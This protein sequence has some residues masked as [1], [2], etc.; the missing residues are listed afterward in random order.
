MKLISPIHS[1]IV[2]LHC[3][4]LLRYVYSNSNSSERKVSLISVLNKGTTFY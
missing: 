1:H 4:F 3:L 2:S